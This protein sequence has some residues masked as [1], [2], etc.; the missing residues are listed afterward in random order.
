MSA[1]AD[2]APAS[3]SPA[4]SVAS[5]Q[6]PAAPSPFGL[7]LTLDQ[8]F[9]LQVDEDTT[10]AALTLIINPVYRLTDEMSLSLSIAPY[11]EETA[12]PGDGKRADLVGAYT[13]VRFKHAS[14]F[15]EEV[16][17]LNLSGALTLFL[18]LT[19][20]D[21]YAPRYPTPAVSLGVDRSFYGFTAKYS[22]GY[23]Q[24][25]PVDS[26][27]QIDFVDYGDGASPRPDDYR[28]LGYT[29]F[30]KISNTFVLSYVA[31]EKLTT[32]A[33]VVVAHVNTQGPA[34]TDASQIG[35]ELAAGSPGNDR[36]T[37]A[38]SLELAY[39]LD[40]TYSVGLAYANLESPQRPTGQAFGGPGS[41]AVNG[42]PVALFFSEQASTVSVNFNAAY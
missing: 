4:A 41:D 18:P 1:A 17:G 27:N 15:K 34:T 30:N 26:T 35:N 21:V 22:I 7:N 14:I 28:V 31:L 39:D 37:F 29:S 2:E 16:T 24:Y 23:T 10:S 8:G 40:D 13:Y 11:V 42:G 19:R 12:S 33:S 36:D 3:S 32:T 5:E 9:G 25:L 6:K 38:F 20:N